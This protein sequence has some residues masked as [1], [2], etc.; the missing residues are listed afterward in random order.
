ME[1]VSG[2]MSKQ[3]K[4]LEVFAPKGQGA[5]I[6]KETLELMRSIPEWLKELGVLAR[7]NDYYI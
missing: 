6:G 3:K 4:G 1:R 5:V 7:K 2:I